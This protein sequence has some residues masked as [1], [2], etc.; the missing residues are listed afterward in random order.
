MRMNLALW[1]RWALAFTSLI[2][3]SGCFDFPKHAT[4]PL[5]RGSPRRTDIGPRPAPRLCSYFRDAIWQEFGF[6]VDSPDEVIYTA[7]SLW[8]SVNESRIELWEP[9]GGEAN[10]AVVWQARN[11]GVLA[12]YLAEGG[13]RRKLVSVRVDM[14]PQPS[15]AQIIACLGAPQS[16]S[17][18]LTQDNELLLTLSLWYPEKGFVVYGFSYDAHVQSTAFQPG[19]R[20][21]SFSVVS[22]GSLEER[23]SDLHHWSARAYILCTYRPW[24]GSIEAIEVESDLE[25]PR[26]E[27]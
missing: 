12:R 13:K 2:T 14:N 4:S 26:C 3:L 16:H 24:P 7:T 5:Q 18:T 22:P 21:D 27:L 1:M 23:V 20:M 8:K 17:A 15:L 19:F 10:W 25:N 11:D 9:Y 6:G